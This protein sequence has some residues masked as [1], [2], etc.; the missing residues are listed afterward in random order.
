MAC[1][2]AKGTIFPLSRDRAHK[3]RVHHLVVR[4]LAMDARGRFLVQRRSPTR[5]SYPGAYTD[6]ASGHVSFRLGLLFDL[7]RALLEDAARE[8][9]EEVGVTVANRNG[10]L[11]RPFGRPVYSPDAYETSHCFVARVG[12][13]IRPSDEVDPA[14]TRFVGRPRLERM[15]EKEEFVPVARELWRALLEELGNR[16]PEDVFFHRI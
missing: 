16:D 5:E 13:K 12:G 4:V 15:L 2:G 3:D 7:Q 10:P 8:L 14:K 9:E 1:I 6:S 11:I